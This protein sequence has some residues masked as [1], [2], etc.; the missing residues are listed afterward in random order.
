MDEKNFSGELNRALLVI[1][2][3]K[4]SCHVPS[5]FFFLN[6]IGGLYSFMSVTSLIK[7]SK[8]KLEGSSIQVQIC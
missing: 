5:M 2:R 3:T 1:S 6:Q 8:I 7:R 4:E